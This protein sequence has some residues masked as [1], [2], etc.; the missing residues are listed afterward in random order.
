[1]NRIAFVH[2]IHGDARIERV[3]DRHSVI[4]PDEWTFTKVPAAKKIILQPSADDARHLP[5]IIDVDLF[6]RFQ[7]AQ[8]V[9]VLALSTSASVSRFRDLHIVDARLL[10]APRVTFDPDFVAGA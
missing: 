7:K 5:I 3:L 2:P 1:M 8:V 10:P 4:G 6:G 9:P